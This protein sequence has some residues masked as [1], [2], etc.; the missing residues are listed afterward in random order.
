[1]LR[2]CNSFSWL[3]KTYCPRMEKQCK[4]I[5]GD[6]EQWSD[7]QTQHKH[8]EKGFI[9]IAAVRGFGSFPHDYLHT[10]KIRETGL[11]NDNA[12]LTL[13]RLNVGHRDMRL[14]SIEPTNRQLYWHHSEEIV[15][16]VG[17]LDCSVISLCPTSSWI[18][19][20]YL[21][22]RGCGNGILTSIAALSSKSL[23][24]NC[25]TLKT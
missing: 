4:Q 5:K 7:C 9:N 8:L 22:L 11:T 23:C 10:Q 18:G 24:N 20:N 1:M 14:P 15:G 13:I 25:T 2:F 21:Q 3:A 6:R 19:V 12:E 16:L 17:A